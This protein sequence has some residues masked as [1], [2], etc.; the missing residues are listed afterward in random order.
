MLTINAQFL[1]E[2]SSQL[3][4]YNYICDQLGLTEEERKNPNAGLW[5][6]DR[7]KQLQTAALMTEALKSRRTGN[8]IEDYVKAPEIPNPLVAKPIE[9]P[10]P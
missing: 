5:I 4:C 1:Y 10:I 3:L 7:M 6:I 9:T 8:T 2:I